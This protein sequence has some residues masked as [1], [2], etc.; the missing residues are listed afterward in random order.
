MTLV[1][2]VWLLLPSLRPYKLPIDNWVSVLRGEPR[3]VPVNELSRRGLLDTA[4]WIRHN[5]PPTDSPLD[6]AA[7]PEYGLMAMWGYGHLL[8][9]AAQ[10]PTVVGNFGDDVGETNLGLMA[11]YFASTEP[12]AVEILDDLGARYVLVGTLNDPTAELRLGQAMRKRLSLDDSPGLKHHRL[13]FESRLDAT[14]LE[15]GRSE[16]RVFERVPGAVIVGS[17]RPGATVTAR[18][19]YESNRGRRGRFESSVT[20]GD[21]G[22]YE[23]RVPYATRGG[24]PGLRP[25]PTYR[26]ASQGRTESVV[27]NERDVR[28]GAEIAGPHL[29]KR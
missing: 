16:Y 22:R 24:P 13:V 14:W 4:M 28:A 1:L 9:Y 6:P 10:R 5:T 2:C 18:L 23:I 15:I 8:K 26:V 3:S 19:G 27:V 20:A 7:S 11:A 17:A 12:G 21:Q 29:S 25:D